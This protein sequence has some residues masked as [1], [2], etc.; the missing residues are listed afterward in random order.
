M[1]KKRDEAAQPICLKTAGHPAKSAAPGWRRWMFPATGLLSL[2][3]FLVRVTPKPSRAAYPCQRAAA[4]L[5]GGFVVWVASVLASASFYRRAK[6]LW[7]QSR[8]MLACASLVIA[9]LLAISALVNVA[10]RPAMANDPLP[11]QPIGVAKGLYPGRVVWVHNPKATNWEGPGHEHW[12]EN[13]HTNQAMVDSM[14]S[15]AIRRLGGKAT[16]R[17]AWDALIKHF[18]HTRGNGSAGY[19][20]GEKIT[21]KVNFVGCIAGG[22]GGV[23]PKSYDLVRQLDYMNTSPQMILALLRQLVN[24]AGVNQQDISV[25]DP[26]ALFPNQYYDLLHGEFPNVHYLDHD[27][28]NAAHPRTR[29]AP[30]STPFY[31]SSRPAGNEQDFVPAPYVEAKYFINLANLKSHT[32][33]GVTLCGKNHYG[34][35][36]RKPNSKGY[37]DM[38]ESLPFKIAGSGHYRALV[39]L[40]GHAQ[41]G[42]KTLLYLIDGLYPGVH[43]KETSPRQWFTAP[44]NAHWASS[45]FASQDPVAIDSVAFDFLWAE[46]KD[47]PHMSG[48]ED[49]LYEAALANN[50]PSGTFYDPDHATN[51][52]RLASLGVHEHWN[53]AQEKQYSRNLGKAEGIELLPVGAAR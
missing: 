47:Y 22:G 45:L 52:T 31:W 1:S 7:R 11:N 40:M 29:V 15:A 8:L 18:N 12:W 41:T 30:S 20:K 44:F 16:D 38:H 34:S 50:P 25:G 21:I 32:A 9:A 10:D 14:M 28:G 19:R 46:W 35:L 39:D 5:A 24:A 53:N 49:Y 4:P 48:A 13:G 17:E 51:T 3:W 26:L 23:D 42:G 43:P 36:I 2:I 27:G 33:A 6:R 37:Y